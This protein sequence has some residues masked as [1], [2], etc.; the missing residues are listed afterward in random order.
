MLLLAAIFILYAATGSH[1]KSY[2]FLMK[3]SQTLITLY[4]VYVL[5]NFSNSFYGMVY[6]TP[7]PSD[8]VAQFLY[9]SSQD[10]TVLFSCCVGLGMFIYHSVKGVFVQTGIIKICMYINAK[11][12]KWFIA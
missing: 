8:E 5:I 11:I 2:Q 9:S 4:S 6:V 12:K 10:T 3:A 1:E 7:V